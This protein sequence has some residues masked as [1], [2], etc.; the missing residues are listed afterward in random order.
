MQLLC[1]NRKNAEQFMN[2]ILC[3]HRCKCETSG[4]YQLRAK[5]NFEGASRYLRS[6]MSITPSLQIEQN[7]RT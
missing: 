5:W 7:G 4:W 3:Y 6:K 2:G 1:G